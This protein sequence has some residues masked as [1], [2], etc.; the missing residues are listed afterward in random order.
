MAQK[1]IKQEKTLDLLPDEEKR[2]A[3]KILEKLEAESEEKLSFHIP[4]QDEKKEE[5]KKSNW[6]ASRRLKKEQNKKDA[7]R[8]RGELDVKVPEKKVKPLPKPKVLAPEVFSDIVKKQ[9][10]KSWWERKKKPKKLPQ[11]KP[12]PIPIPQP[13][14]AKPLTTQKIEPKK[15]K[16]EYHEPEAD[17]FDSLGVNLVPEYARAQKQGQRLILL[18]GILVLVVATWVIVGGLNVNKVKQAE[19]E[20]AQKQ[21]QLDKVNRLISQSQTDKKV[22]ESLQK[23]FIAVSSLVR[24]HYYWLP[25]FQRLEE[26]TLPDIYYLRLSANHS[27]VIVIEAIAKN[28]EAAARQI[29]AFE[30]SPSFISGVEVNQAQLRPQP[31]SRLPVPVVAFTLELQLVDDFLTIVEAETQ[32]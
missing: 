25:L 20:I 19:A 30:K 18:S 15:E 3:S 10:E 16:E 27:G 17:G 28:Y 11:A 8:K 29:R 23:Q 5:S 26:T 31:G 22:A 24:N 32:E 9:P 1:K 2:A 12:E 13:A 7:L 14:V 6:F 4:E 21:N